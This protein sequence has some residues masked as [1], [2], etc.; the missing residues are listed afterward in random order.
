MYKL[1]C[2]FLI[3]VVAV[4]FL[5]QF[6]SSENKDTSSTKSDLKL[7]QERVNLERDCVRICAAADYEI[8]AIRD[9]WKAQCANSYYF[10]G[11]TSINE[12]MASCEN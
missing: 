3:L 11:K 1:G 7:L 5:S 6:P 10:G 9:E 2:F 8:P 4:F 12:L